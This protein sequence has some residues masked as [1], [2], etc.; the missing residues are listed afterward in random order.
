[1]DMMDNIKAG[2]K[3]WTDDGEIADYLGKILRKEAYDGTGLIYGI[4]HAVYTLSD[5]RTILLKQKAGILAAER[6]K[7]RN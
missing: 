5:P 4:G 3:D 6:D 1:M 7:R 2:V